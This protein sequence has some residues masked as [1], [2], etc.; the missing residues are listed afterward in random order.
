MNK[1][2]FSQLKNKY[3]GNRYKQKLKKMLRI[4]RGGG[5]GDCTNHKL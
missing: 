1:L 3:V 2:S 4:L 5:G